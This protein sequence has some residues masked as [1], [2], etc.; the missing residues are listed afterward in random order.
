LFKLKNNPLQQARRHRISDFPLQVPVSLN[1]DFSFSELGITHRAALSGKMTR[2]RHSCFSK[3][4]EAFD[5]VS[6][7]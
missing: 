4:R 7:E 2:G 6:E 3:I 1:Q 5:V